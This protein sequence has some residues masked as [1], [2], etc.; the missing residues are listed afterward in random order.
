[1]RAV[2]PIDG[3]DAMRAARQ[4]LSAGRSRT[5]PRTV[6]PPRHVTDARLAA[7]PGLVAAAFGITRRH[8]GT[9]LCDSASALRLEAPLAGEPPPVVVAGPRVGIA[10]AAE[11]WA[12]APWRFTIA[13][14]PSISGRPR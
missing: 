7:G 6:T 12:S 11:P 13:G 2:E 4:A 5:P 3:V 14:S 1:V 9:D 8:T 10:Y